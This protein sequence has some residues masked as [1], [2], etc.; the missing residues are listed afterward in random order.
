LSLFLPNLSGSARRFEIGFAFQ[1]TGPE[2]RLRFQSQKVRVSAEVESLV[3]K[4]LSI[5]GRVESDI[6]RF[7]L[8]D[9][10]RVRDKVVRTAGANYL[11]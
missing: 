9:G 3:P 6:Q 11:A 8:A 7:E 5:L 1:S 4:V 2:S 10:G